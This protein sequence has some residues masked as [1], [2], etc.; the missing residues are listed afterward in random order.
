MT[1]DKIAAYTTLYTVLTTLAKLSA[2]FTPFMAETIYQNLVPNFYKDAPISVHLTS[3]P[4][5][6]ETLIDKE[7]EKG[8][9]NVLDIVVL[10]RAVRNASNV[11]NRQPLSKVFV[12]AENQDK[13][14]AELAEIAKDELNV[15]ELEYL[16]KATDFISYTVKP[17]L[18]TLGPKYGSKLGVI[19]NYLSTCD[20]TALVMEVKE[21]G[22]FTV[23]LDGADITF[24]APE[25]RDVNTVFQNYALFPHMNVEQN[26]SY[27]LRMR[28]EKKEV[29]RRK[30]KEMLRLVQMEGREKRMP[31]QLSGGQ[32]QR[33]AIARALALQPQ[34]L[35]FDEPTSA[36]DPELTGEVLRVIR[37]LKD[38]GNT[39]IVVTHEMEFARSVADV[40]I[41]MADGV[42]EEM[43]TPEE[44]FGAPR[45]E[46]T[47]AFIHGAAQIY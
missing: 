12:C 45:S 31:G 26:I 1:D 2:P 16:D 44:V 11:K 46:K 6:D 32:R 18:K 13:L 8:M 25:K 40:V 24:A 33:I 14:S 7:L 37:A 34:V 23:N 28:G 3:F 41:H 15:K 21:K 29:W 19:R 39:M 30:V 38:K 4:K 20:G 9:E 10:G 36:L 17:Q 47:R 43:G 35:C 22:S 5:A 42:I 27:G